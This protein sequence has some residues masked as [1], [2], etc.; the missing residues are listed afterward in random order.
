MK[1]PGSWPSRPTSAKGRRPAEAATAQDVTARVTARLKSAG[2]GRGKLII[3]HHVIIRVH[4][5][6]SFVE[7]N[8]I[9]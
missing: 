2:R 9:L 5:E 6:L 1:D 3:A 8:G 7:S 4:F